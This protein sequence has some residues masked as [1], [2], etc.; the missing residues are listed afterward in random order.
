MQ[1]PHD[2]PAFHTAIS[3]CNAS[4]PPM[5]ARLRLKST[6][7]IAGY[8]THVQKVLQAMKTYGMIMADG[9][10]SE[11]VTGDYNSHWNDFV[12]GVSGNTWIDIFNG[13]VTSTNGGGNP[14]NGVHLADFEY[15]VDPGGTQATGNDRPLLDP[16]TPLSPASKCQGSAGFT[17]TV[18][19]DTNTGNFTAS[20]TVK[21]N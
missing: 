8:E 6:F 20:S 9:G 3:P 11:Y 17:L 7:N 14:T 13:Q 2:W 12:N 15:I 4:A 18:K 19:I 21:V 5:G 1:I 10:T 16:T